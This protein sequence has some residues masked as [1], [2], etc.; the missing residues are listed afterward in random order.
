MTKKVFIFTAST[1]S[2]HN[3]AA[4]SLE[5]ALSKSGFETRIL[6]AFKES[7]AVLDRIMSE[8]YK[9]LVEN[10]PRFYEQMYKKF[11]KK[12]PFREHVFGRMSR[13]MNPELVPL[14]QEEK[15]DLIISTHP[16]VTRLLGTIKEHADIDIPVLAFVTD[17][18]IH[19]V[20]IHKMI[21]A[22]VVGSEYTKKTM[23]DLGVSPDI[24]FPFGIPIRRAFTENKTN[25]T[26]NNSKIKG[27]VLLMAGSLGSKN[28]EKAFSALMKIEKP[29]RL[30]VVCGNNEKVFRSIEFLKKVYQSEDKLVDIYGF[31][32]NI[33]ELMDDS[34]IIITKPG[35]LTSTE[36]IMKNIPMIIP[37]C[38]PGQEEENADYLVESGMAI[39]VKK[40]KDLTPTLDF[41]IENQ[42]IIKEMS[43]TM[44]EESRLHSMEKT[45]SLCKKLTQTTN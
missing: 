43:E 15:P 39:K 8:G 19:D 38:Y 11:N 9:Q 44:S 1:G 16:F 41:L 21:N 28:M 32:N 36:A 2:G 27:T 20:Y 25:T 35:G 37:F 17:Y 31:V 18:K 14:I 26:K 45:V 7:S 5:D 42:Y 10:A 13:L 23:M 24:I 30:I 34:D 3:L 29:I 12:T 22:Y 4:Q 40:I 6:D 33:P